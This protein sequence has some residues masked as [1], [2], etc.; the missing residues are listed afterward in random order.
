MN[1]HQTKQLPTAL[2]ITGSGKICTS[3][4]GKVYT[5]DTTH[6]NYKTILD[7]V[8]A[9]DWT[10][11]VQLVDLTAP[12]KSY[13][14]NSKSG[15]KVQVND[16]AITYEGNVIHNTLTKRILSFITEGLPF[17][18]LVK[19]LE[20]LM[21][22]P[23]KR[24]VDEL[25]G[26]LEAGELPITEDGYFLAYKNV[27]G[28]YKDIHS[29]TFDNSV[30]QV[31]KMARNA[32]DEDK[33]QTCSYGLHFCSIKYL[34]N[35]T[36]SDGGHTMI[37]KINPANVVAIPGDY[38]NTKGRCC[39]YEVAGEYT[40]D[41]RKHIEEGNN[42]FTDKVYSTLNGQIYGV[43]PSGQSFYNVRDGSGKFIKQTAST[44][45]DDG[46]TYDSGDDSD[47]DEGYWD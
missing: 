45:Y 16:G 30:G 32:V 3:I 28:D 21:Q 29:G 4:N 10:K 38:A 13:I 1:T 43:K 47:S 27:R 19:F 46:D 18:P 23:S 24:A 25:Y 11:F 26:F 6:T 31:C 39:E 41:W 37:L 20:N 33:D 8:K 44:V 2:T 5:V 40:E 35:F 34:P 17:E 7:T 12:V 22:N 42:G 14:Q 15:G 36:W 9:Q